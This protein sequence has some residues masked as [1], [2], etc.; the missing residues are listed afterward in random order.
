MHYTKPR[1]EKRLGLLS[2]D[3]W[4]QL[5]EFVRKD[6]PLFHKSY[7]LT[8]LL[9]PRGELLRV[10]TDAGRSLHTAHGRAL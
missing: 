10:P 3:L 2:L 7:L 6:G 4:D 9:H 1:F 5:A 8:T